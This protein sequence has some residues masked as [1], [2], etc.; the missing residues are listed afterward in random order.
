MKIFSCD[1]HAT[2]ICYIYYKQ[3]IC[4]QFK[5][6]IEGIENHSNVKF[7]FLLIIDTT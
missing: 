7:S 4:S 1:K 2:C 5:F 6:K 3:I